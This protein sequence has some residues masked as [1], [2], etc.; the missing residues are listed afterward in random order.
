VAWS[1]GARCRRADER[2]VE[3]PA[4]ASPAVAAISLRHQQRRRPA[5]RRS[6]RSTTR[7]SRSCT[8]SATRWPKAPR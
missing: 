8:R 3:L 4:R 5:Q 7:T 6:A 1:I 2:R